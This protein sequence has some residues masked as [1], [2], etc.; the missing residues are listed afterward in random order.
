MLQSQ[1][2]LVGE[3][4]SRHM[5]QQQEQGSSGQPAA[6]VLL[7]YCLSD[8]APA[9]AAAATAAT[10]AAPPSSSGSTSTSVSSSPASWQQQLLPALQQLNGLKLLPLA[11]GQ[12]QTIYAGLH[13]GRAGAGVT[14]TSEQQQC[15]DCAVYVTLSRHEQQLLQGLKHHLLHQGVGEGLRQQLKAV[16]AAGSSNIHVLTAARLD[17]HVLGLLMPP[18]W[19]SSLGH[20][21]FNWHPEQLPHQQGQQPLGGQQQPAAAASGVVEAADAVA[22]QQQQQQQ[23]PSKEFIRLCWRW[24]AERG[25]AADVSHWP[26]LPVKGGKLRL[27]QQPAQ[28]RLVHCG[29]LCMFWEWARAHKLQVCVSDSTLNTLDR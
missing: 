28:V 14:S 9:A 3:T 6:A 16:A 12:L 20:V 1:A 22:T 24:M 23:Q 21:E 7:Q 26:L 2:A 5:R 18:E 15:V 11:D 13:T 29:A 27:L 17:S 8:A 19:H 25:D 10:T 4:L